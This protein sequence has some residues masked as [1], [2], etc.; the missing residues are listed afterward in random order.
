MVLEEEAKELVLVVG[1]GL[2]KELVLES[3]WEL[4]V[5]EVLDSPEEQD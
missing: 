5:E 4:V 1:L 3:E 2:A